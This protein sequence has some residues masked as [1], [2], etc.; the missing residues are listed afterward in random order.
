[1]LEF[2]VPCTTLKDRVTGR[3]GHGI[4]MGPKPYL[5]YKEEYELV[6]FLINCSNMGYGKMRQ[7][8]MKLVE[9]CITKKEDVTLRKSADRGLSNGWWVQFIQRCMST[10]KFA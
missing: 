10:V 4:R 3:V 2:N 5:M 7:D 8:V 1:M 9:C 6:E